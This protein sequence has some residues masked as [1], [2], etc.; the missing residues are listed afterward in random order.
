M[1]KSN[2]KKQDLYGYI[3]IE[4]LLNFC[5]NSKDHSIT[6][7]EFMRFTRHRINEAPTVEDRYSEGY[8]DGYL[9]G[10]S[11]ADIREIDDE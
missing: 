3:A 5:E 2:D 11:G 4:D 1:E 6:P 8:S 10:M 9:D 7:N